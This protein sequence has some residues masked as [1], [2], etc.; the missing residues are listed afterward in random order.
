[1]SGWIL[2]LASAAFL[3]GLAGGVHCA[4]MCGPIA[5]ACATQ[6]GSAGLRWRRALAYNAGRIASYTFAGLAVGAVGQEALALRPGAAAQQIA[7]VAAGASM[8]LVALYFSGVT[9]VARGM[10]S[11]GALVWK[12]VQPWSRRF[13]PAD[14]AGKAFGL[15]TLWGWLPCGMVYGMLLTAAATGDA[16]EGGLVMLSFGLGTLPNML[17]VGMLANGVRT[18]TRRPA[19]RLVIAGV[20]GVA[21]IA[22]LASAAHP[23]WTAAVLC[24]AIQPAL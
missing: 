14:T 7:L 23:H 24:R 22:A 2:W 6:S 21:G 15:G 9:V 3:A 16:A 4:A 19:V 8:L 1:M 13:L 10:E 18:Y 5:A 20:I 12:H 17:A 11:A